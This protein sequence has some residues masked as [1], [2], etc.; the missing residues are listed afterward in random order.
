MKPGLGAVPQ[1]LLRTQPRTH[2][3][4]SVI[5]STQ[6]QHKPGLPGSRAVPSSSHKDIPLSVGIWNICNLIPTS[7][8][9]IRFSAVIHWSFFD[10]GRREIPFSEVKQV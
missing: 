2:K 6:D 4:D 10:A 3:E 5:G 1:T 7:D 8:S 9:E